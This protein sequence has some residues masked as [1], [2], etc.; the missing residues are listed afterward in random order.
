MAV[1]TLGKVRRT[2]EAGNQRIRIARVV[3]SQHCVRIRSTMRS[4]KGGWEVQ[5]KGN[6]TNVDDWTTASDGRFLRPIPVPCHRLCPCACSVEDREDLRPPIKNIGIVVVVVEG[7]GKVCTH[8]VHKYYV[9]RLGNA[10]KKMWSS[11]GLAL[12][13]LKRPGPPE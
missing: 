3:V 1:V 11:I 9:V 2:S 13:T 8:C 5:A 12:L 7:R 6:W 4:Q 10:K